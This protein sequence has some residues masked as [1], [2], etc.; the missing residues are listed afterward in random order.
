M[1]ARSAW[2]TITY[3]GGD[4]REHPA[5]VGDGSLFGG[6]LVVRDPLG[7]CLVEIQTP[8]G[9]PTGGIENWSAPVSVYGGEEIRTEQWFRR[10]D[11][12]A[13]MKLVDD[14]GDFH[15]ARGRE[16]L[17]LLLARPEDD[18]ITLLYPRAGKSNALVVVPLRGL[19][20]AFESLPASP[21]GL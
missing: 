12:V 1:P 17:D 6:C 16:L 5:L 2:R 3:I 9:N 8:R 14:R 7:A 19:R 21:G 4:D 18:E 10:S 20:V 15:P 11:R 13:I